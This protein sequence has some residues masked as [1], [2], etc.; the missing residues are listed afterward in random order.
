MAIAKKIAESCNCEAY[1]GKNEPE[2]YVDSCVSFAAGCQCRAD[3]DEYINA[4]LD[5][6]V[7]C[8]MAR[9]CQINR[10]N[11]LWIISSTAHPSHTWADAIIIRTEA[12]NE[13]K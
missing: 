7:T 6:W 11:P 12:K 10:D 3:A 8:G 4:A 13:T 1:R 9:G 2:P 5:A